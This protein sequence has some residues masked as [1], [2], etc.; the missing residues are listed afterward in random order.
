[1]SVLRGLG[2]G[3]GEAGVGESMRKEALW[4]TRVAH[5]VRPP[6]TGTLP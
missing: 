5:G 6:S 2:G 1:M 3:G 4:T